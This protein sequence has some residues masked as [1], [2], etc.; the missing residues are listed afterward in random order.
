[1][2]VTC[3]DGLPSDIRR[4]HELM[5]IGL[6]CFCL[7]S[8]LYL[9]VQLQCFSVPFGSFSSQGRKRLQIE[10]SASPGLILRCVISTLVIWVIRAVRKKLLDF[11]VK[12][13]RVQDY[14]RSNMYTG[15]IFNPRRYRVYYK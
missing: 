10:K 9:L 15:Q 14:Y 13:W 3:V 1:M 2:C 6:C 7:C 12:G 4:C 11:H 5:L 8:N